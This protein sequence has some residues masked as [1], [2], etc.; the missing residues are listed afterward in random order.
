M[1]IEQCRLA[2]CKKNEL[3]NLVELKSNQKLQFF[4]KIVP[5]TEP[6]SFL[7]NCTPPFLGGHFLFTCSVILIVIGIQAVGCRGKWRVGC[8]AAA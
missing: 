5:K 8:G 2:E 1:N 3:K 4:C 6:K 7:V